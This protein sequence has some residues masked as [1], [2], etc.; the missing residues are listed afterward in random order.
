MNI[1]FTMCFTGSFLFLLYWIA[2]KAFRKC[3]SSCWKYI[4]LKFVLLFF[5]TP[6]GF[7]KLLPRQTTYWADF[8]LAG[9][10]PIIVSTD[11]G[12]Y[13]NFTYQ[14]DHAIV[15]LWLIMA[16][17]IFFWQ[18]FKYF[19][20]KGLI[21]KSMK[22][23]TVSETLEYIEQYRQ[24]LGIKRKV[25]LFQSDYISPFTTGIL[26]PVVV[27]PAGLTAEKQKLILKHELVHIRRYD[28][29][30]L[31]LRHLITCFYWFNPL[32]YLL[33]AQLEKIVEISCDES[34]ILNMEQKERKDYASLI[35]DMAAYDIQY[36]RTYATSFSSTTTCLKERMDLIMI[37]E[38]KKKHGKRLSVI[39]ASC[40]VLCSSFTAFA[41]QP[42]TEIDMVC[43]N[44]NN[45]FAD[46]SSSDTICFQSG[47][48]QPN[49]IFSSI[50]YDNQFTDING[51]IYNIDE[52]NRSSY[53]ACDHNYIDGTMSKHSKKSDG[54]CITKYYDSQ[55]C[56]KCGKIILG[57]LIDT[58]THSIC[59][60]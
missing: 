24:M 23:I 43:N 29:L 22:E 14:T 48:F 49:N 56:T 44:E 47:E 60:H 45:P 20:L 10:I 3:L 2:T 38:K 32:V 27:L 34:V 30:F 16:A 58:E 18:Q 17:A 1:I 11:Q 31:F 36:Q 15:F 5:L 4:V 28:I 42:S 55:R 50:L 33:E 53:A 8:H 7:L 37:P 19:H 13:P 25:R 40:M 54:S 41:Y 26:S 59:P 21:M 46:I 35:I 6:L 52:S 57:S 12:R 9:D 39:L 51:N